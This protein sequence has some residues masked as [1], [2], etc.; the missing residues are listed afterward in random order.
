MVMRD[1]PSPRPTFVLARGA[2]DAPTE[3][4][5]PGTPAAILPYPKDLPP[6][7]LGLARWLVSPSNPLTA[8]VFANRYWAMAFGRGI[9]STADDFG[10]QGQMP[11]HPELLDWLATTLVSSG[12]D[13]KA[14]LRTIVTSATYRQ[15]SIVDA[16]ARAADP[17]NAWLARGPSFRMPAEQVRDASLAASGLLVRSIG[18]PSVYPYQPEGL[19]ESLV[20]GARY[21]QSSGEGLYRRSL[22]TAWKR[23]APPPS[24]VGFDASERL[25]CIVTRQRTNTPQQALILLNDP[26]YV[27]SARVLAEEVVRAG[28]TPV[29][30][31]TRAMRRVISRRP[32]PTELAHLTR[33]HDVERARFAGNPAAATAVLATGER[34]RDATLDPVDLAAWTVVTS[35]IMNLDEA[36]FSR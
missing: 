4:V 34:P 6:N 14:L 30:R 15:S 18:G 22:Y 13:G 28:G 36:V 26:Q 35:T 19:W 12:W 23:T 11:T 24:A 5:T 17:D 27:E 1:L 2:Y 10:S 31:I 16:E 25:A 33:L 3:R 32:S 29:E 20:A 8:R 9:V 7:R 21:P